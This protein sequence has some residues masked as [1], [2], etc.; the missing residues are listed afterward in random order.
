[1]TLVNKAAN[2]KINVC[3]HQPKYAKFIKIIRRAIA[4][5]LL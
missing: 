1:M 2:V 5:V 4:T 3:R